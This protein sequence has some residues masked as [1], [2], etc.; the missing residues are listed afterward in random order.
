MKPNDLYA[1]PL[2]TAIFIVESKATR[3]ERRVLKCERAQQ[4]LLPWKRS[5][6]KWENSSRKG[7]TEEG[8]S[9]PSGRILHQPR[10]NSF[11]CKYLISTFL[12]KTILLHFRRAI[13]WNEFEFQ[14]S[15]Q[16]RSKRGFWDRRNGKRIQLLNWDDWRFYEKIEFLSSQ[17]ITLS[18]W[19]ILM[20]C[21]DV[22]SKYPSFV[23]RRS[24]C[25]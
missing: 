11:K 20:C 3:A 7:Q 16:N 21:W 2:S 6:R 18:E 5:S 8:I 15:N 24:Q 12:L 13:F 10:K 1:F 9:I 25:P 17:I 22:R 4:W 19:P 23:L 14:R